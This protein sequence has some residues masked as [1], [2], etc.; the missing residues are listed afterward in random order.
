MAENLTPNLEQ[1]SRPERPVMNAETAS[2]RIDSLKNLIKYGN[3]KSYA[4]DM[5]M[6]AERSMEA[7]NVA[8]ADILTTEGLTAM[9]YEQ[10]R[11]LAKALGGDAHIMSAQDSLA[12]IAKS[13]QYGK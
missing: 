9:G 10:T 11:Q 5:V 1:A 7:G 8:L 13:S 4:N 3:F 6:L 12:T 2:F